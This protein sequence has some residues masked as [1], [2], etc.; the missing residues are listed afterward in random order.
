MR[1]WGSRDSKKSRNQDAANGLHGKF[2]LQKDPDAIKLASQHTMVEETAWFTAC[3]PEKGIKATTSRMLGL[4][5]RFGSIYSYSQ[6]DA[7]S[8]GG[9]SKRLTPV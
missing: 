9:V 3:S 1:S 7:G 5:R 6:N 4:R 8:E 2:S